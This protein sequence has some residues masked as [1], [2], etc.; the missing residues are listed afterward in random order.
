MSP[1]APMEEE[2]TEWQTASSLS[3]A[4]D[5]LYKD[6][7]KSGLLHALNPY[8]L[9]LTSQDLESVV[10]LENSSFEPGIAA[11]REKVV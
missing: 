1:Q 2:Q 5:R 11:S 4:D 7:R 8:K 6:M 10:A 9:A 3:T